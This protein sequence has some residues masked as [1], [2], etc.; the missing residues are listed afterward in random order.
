MPQVQDALHHPLG[1]QA[2]L[3]RQLEGD[4]LAVAQ[5]APER[6]AQALG[7]VGDDG[8]GRVEDALGAAV[9]L[10]QLDLHRLREILL[11]IQDVADVGPPPPIDGVVGHEAVGDERVDPLHI[12]VEDGGT[13]L[14]PC[15]IHHAVAATRPVEDRHA[16][17]HVA[18]RKER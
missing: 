3:L 1:L 12:Q 16:R 5:V 14:D 18:R 15:H 17:L 10:L 4:G 11:E 13:E 6:L 8:A 9:V 2:A 7:V